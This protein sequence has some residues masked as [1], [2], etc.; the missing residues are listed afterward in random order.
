MKCCPEQLRNASGE[1]RKSIN[2][3]ADLRIAAER[4]KAE[5]GKTRGFTDISGEELPPGVEESTPPP[6]ETGLRLFPF[7]R[8][9]LLRSQLR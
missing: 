1:E 5:K 7:R 6:T 8:R 2:V 9:R 4:L 3:D